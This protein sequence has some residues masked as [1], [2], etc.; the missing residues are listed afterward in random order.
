MQGS[1]ISYKQST[2]CINFS[3]R[4]HYSR[5]TA[6]LSQHLY[7]QIV[8]F[9]GTTLLAVFAQYI[10]GII[11]DGAYELEK[12]NTSVDRCW[13]RSL[14]PQSKSLGKQPHIQ[15]LLIAEWNFQVVAFPLMLNLNVLLGKTTLWTGHIL[16]PI[17][18]R[19]QNSL[20]CAFIS[21]QLEIKLC[22]HAYH[23]I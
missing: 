16:G 2:I 12:T 19:A 17:N 15:N 9:F 11:V 7:N 4:V 6:A 10:P 5:R 22:M 20:V 23:K 8:V 3:W 18:A 14:V 1:D 13:L 21:P